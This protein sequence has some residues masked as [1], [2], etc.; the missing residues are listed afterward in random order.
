MLVYKG[1][2]CY[3]MH[4]SSETWDLTCRDIV[5]IEAAD[6]GAAILDFRGDAKNPLESF[7]RDLPQWILHPGYFCDMV[8]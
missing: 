2:F 4:F 6:R 3:Q 5:S 1:E 8:Y 7:S